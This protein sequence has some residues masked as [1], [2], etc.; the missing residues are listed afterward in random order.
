[1]KNVIG[2]VK[3]DYRR[4]LKISYGRLMISS[5]GMNRQYTVGGSFFISFI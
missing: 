5:I 1:M 2:I 3:E 4:T